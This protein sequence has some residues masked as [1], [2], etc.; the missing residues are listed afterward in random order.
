MNN[1]G[2]K[3]ISENESSL[4]NKEFIETL[5][6]H[7]ELKFDP[8]KDKLLYSLGFIENLLIHNYPK[9]ILYKLNLL[10]FYKTPCAIIHPSAFDFIVGK[11]ILAVTIHSMREEM[12]SD[13]AKIL[14]INKNLF[15]NSTFSL[16]KGFKNGSYNKLSLIHEATHIYQHHNFKASISDEIEAFLN[17]ILIFRITRSNNFNSYII[18]KKTEDG[19]IDSEIFNITKYLWDI[20]KNKN[21][22]D[23][24]RD[25]IYG[26]TNNFLENQSF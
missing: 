26:W 10:N 9:D 11:N 16:I 19:L 3:L 7:K 23:I 25:D 8:N 13:I 18:N 14:G 22:W 4:E 17:E 2:G 15:L 5:S 12:R 21:F 6:N 20:S 1:F 24:S